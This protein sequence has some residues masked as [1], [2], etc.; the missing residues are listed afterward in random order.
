MTSPY[1][2]QALPA[3]ERPRERLLKHGPEAMTNAELIA[4]LLG[5]GMKGIPVL[6]L[7]QHIVA[8]FG[9]LHRL[10]EATVP[11]LCKI[12]GLGPAKAL[13]LK[14]AMGL[15]LRASRKAIPAKYRIEHPIHAYHLIREELEFQTRELFVVILLDAKNY[16]LSHHTVSVGSTTETFVHAKDVFYPAIRH[17]A[18]CM[19]LA[20][21]HPS[22]D[23][24]PSTEDW[25]LTESLVNASR[26]IGIP[27]YDHIIVGHGMYTSLRQKES[28][29]NPSKPIFI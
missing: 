3:E 16:V 13:Q 28:E 4:I 11:E 29:S 19:I 14:A 9:E 25:G 26:L 17:H 5:S 1:S 2:I 8:H 22:G 7:A 10:A 18:A 21:N 20:H 27:I 6:Q 24:T 15:A 23:P 12:K